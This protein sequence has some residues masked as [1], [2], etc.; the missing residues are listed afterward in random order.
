MSRRKKHVNSDAC[1]TINFLFIFKTVVNTSFYECIEKVSVR[2]YLILNQQYI[3]FLII[4]DTC[5]G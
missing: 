5:S 4:P 3:L 1:S 2:Q